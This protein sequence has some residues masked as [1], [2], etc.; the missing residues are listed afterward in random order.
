[1]VYIIR[2]LKI[3]TLPFAI[4]IFYTSVPILFVT[5]LGY[6]IF[7]SLDDTETFLTKVFKKYINWF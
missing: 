6:V 5:G 2:M 4:I 1:M 7:G 3:L